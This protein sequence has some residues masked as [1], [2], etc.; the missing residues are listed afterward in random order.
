MVS[1]AYVGNKGTRLPS[2]ISPLNV[3]NPSL[4]AQYGSKLTDQFTTDTVVDGVAAPYAGWVQ[5]LTNY[6]CTANVAQALLPF[7][8]YCGSVTGLNENLGSSTYHSFQLKVEKRFSQGLYAMLAYTHSKLL[9]S[10]SGV[11][12]ASSA[13]W[14]GTTGS[15]ISPFEMHRNKSLAPDDVPNSF[16][17]AVVYEL[18]IGKG[19]RFLANIPGASRILGGWEITSTIKHSSGTPFWFRGSNCNVP[20]QFRL[21]CIPAVLPGQS[22]FAVSLDSYDPGKVKSLFNPA[23]FEPVSAF[24][25]GTYYGVGPRVTSFRGFPFRNVDIGIGK[26]T[27]I[28]EKLSM[29][30][31]GEAFNALNLHNF[32]CTGN[33]GCQAFNTTVGDTNFGSWGGN[34]SAPRNI[35]IVARIEF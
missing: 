18:P 17:L 21:A 23:A 34:V 25:S 31:R 8:Q 19:K 35:Q 24:S 4:L 29:L 2:Q 27:R 13:T 22:P 28:T 33:G 3:L 26:K 14:N 16:S 1:A 12:Q 10:A 9:T 20:G 30:I 32:T 5:Q 7:P 11:T 6:G 15:V